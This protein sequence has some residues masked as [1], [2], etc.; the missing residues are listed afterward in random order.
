[1]QQVYISKAVVDRLKLEAMSAII[2]GQCTNCDAYGHIADVPMDVPCRICGCKDIVSVTGA[3]SALRLHSGDLI[4]VP[5]RSSNANP[6]A[7]A[8][9]RKL[10]EC[11]AYFGIDYVA[12]RILS[13]TG[14]SNSW[15]NKWMDS[16]D[17][18]NGTYANIFI[19]GSIELLYNLRV[20]LI[21][22]GY[23]TYPTGGVSDDMFVRMIEAVVG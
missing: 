8:I 2:I 22:I 9:D 14:M 17:Y 1:M 19:D 6:D 13:P 11:I 21:A 20:R 23:A 15:R 5:V 10:S 7:P 4:L 3:V 12:E 16:S 18:R